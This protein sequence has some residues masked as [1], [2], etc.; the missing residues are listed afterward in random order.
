M[1]DL[2]F[3]SNECI[4]ILKIDMTLDKAYSKYNKV[5]QLKWNT[6]KRNTNITQKG[7]YTLDSRILLKMERYN[8]IGS[9]NC[10]S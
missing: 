9:K 6:C 5:Y 3:V 4:Q 2:A 1:A 8:H 10:T 7:K